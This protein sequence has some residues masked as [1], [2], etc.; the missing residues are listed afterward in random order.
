[1]KRNDAKLYF[2]VTHGT[3]LAISVRS[4]IVFNLKQASSLGLMNLLVIIS[5]IIIYFTLNITKT[6]YEYEQKR[7][8]QDIQLQTGIKLQT[9]NTHENDT[10]IKITY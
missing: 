9:D 8:K 6:N 5:N 2:C 1:V 4:S 3:R 10:L 7:K